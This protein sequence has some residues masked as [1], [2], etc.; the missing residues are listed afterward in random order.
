MGDRFADFL[1]YFLHPMKMKKS[2]RSNYFT[3]IG[4]LKTVQGG[5]G[6]KQTPSV[7]TT[8]SDQDPHCFP[9]GLKYM[10]I[11]AMLQI[12]RIK[13]AEECSA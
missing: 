8:V 4:N 3:F 9:L 5:G 11:T 10:L 12:N 6:V 1:T 2:L 13:I 7:S